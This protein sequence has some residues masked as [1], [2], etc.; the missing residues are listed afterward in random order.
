[1]LCGTNA[2]LRGTLQAKS[3]NSL[4]PLTF[5]LA[6]TRDDN[7]NMHK[8]GAWILCGL[9]A[10]VAAAASPQ[11]SLT[12][13]QVAVAQAKTARSLDEPATS[14][15]DLPDLQSCVLKLKA[16]CDA[17]TIEQEIAK[18]IL[19]ADPGLEGAESTKMRARLGELMSKLTTQGGSKKS[20]EHGSVPP[21]WP[22]GIDA[23]VKNDLNK[24]KQAA[25]KGL[26]KNNSPQAADAA[27][28]RGSP[29]CFSNRAISNWP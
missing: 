2:G 20:D 16:E 8:H 21:L 22:G 6:A 14:A 7:S 13:Q 24:Q 29:T 27:D 15:R 26:S 23:E 18:K 10:G 9:L 5:I 25:D 12:P 19:P 11:D 4:Y 17:L 1:M 3:S 28:P